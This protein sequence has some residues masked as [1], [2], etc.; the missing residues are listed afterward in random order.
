MIARRPAS[1][2]AL[3]KLGVDVQAIRDAPREER[4]PRRRPVPNPNSD[5][6]GDV[7]PHR[8]DYDRFERD[9]S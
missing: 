5:G 4:P 8:R 6:P 7:A 9:R 1:A 2:A 3:Q